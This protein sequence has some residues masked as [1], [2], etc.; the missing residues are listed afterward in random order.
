MPHKAKHP[1]HYPLCPG[2]AES[3]KRY[4]EKHKHLEGKDLPKDRRP[5]R[6]QYKGAWPRLRA[7]YLKRNPLCVECKKKGLVVEATEVDHIAPIRE[8]PELRLVWSNLQALCKSC[9]SRKTARER[10][11]GQAIG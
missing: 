9:H 1:C 11:S 2:L 5:Y 4:C 10:A 7:L 3:G 8:R 6:P